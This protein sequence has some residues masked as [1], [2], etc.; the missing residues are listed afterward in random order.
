MSQDKP[1]L[2]QF[3]LVI[4]DT[5]F[6]RFCK[7]KLFGGRKLTLARYLG[8]YQIVACQAVLVGL[9]FRHAPLGTL[10]LICEEGKEVRLAEVLRQQA[11]DVASE[12]RREEVDFP[13]VAMFREQK[14]LLDKLGE[15]NLPDDPFALNRLMCQRTVDLRQAR[16]NLTYCFA[17]FLGLGLFES[18]WIMRAYMRFMP[19]EDQLQK[20]M[21][22]LEE[23][24]KGWVSELRPTLLAE[25]F[26]S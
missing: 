5:I 11:S 19:G 24:V 14:R 6:P 21:R 7:K 18:D 8:A 26:P 17:L 12:F 22:P 4:V 23:L 15:A 9:R 20:D 10:K 2:G 16:T 13:D 25:L 1:T 3:D